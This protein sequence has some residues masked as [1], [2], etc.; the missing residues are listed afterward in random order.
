MILTASCSFYLFLPS[1]S[2]IGNQRPK[3]NQAIY[4]KQKKVSRATRPLQNKLLQLNS[5]ERITHSLSFLFYFIFATQ[6]NVKSQKVCHLEKKKGCP[7]FF[8][9]SQATLSQETFLFFFCF[10]YLYWK[11]C[12]TWQDVLSKQFVVLLEPMYGNQF[13]KVSFSVF[14]YPCFNRWLLHV[15]LQQSLLLLLTKLSSW[16]N[17]TRK[18]DSIC[19]N[20]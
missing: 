8:E 3:K 11:C 1:F 19:L 6:N 16:L 5:K 9:Q 7:F 17:R 13:E 2:L 12:P 20:V 10:S 4:K 14:M 18:R 15:Q